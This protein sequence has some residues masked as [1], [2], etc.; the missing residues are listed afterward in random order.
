MAP[1]ISSTDRQP[2]VLSDAELSER[3]AFQAVKEH[4]AKFYQITDISRNGAALDTVA[5]ASKIKEELRARN[6]Q[7]K[8]I[9][10]LVL[11]V[12]Q[13]NIVNHRSINQ[14]MG[15]KDSLGCYRYSQRTTEQTKAIWNVIDEGPRKLHEAD[16]AAANRRRLCTTGSLTRTRTAKRYVSLTLPPGLP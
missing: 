6:L 8:L 13:G 10:E 2:V 16:K 11:D 1:M 5:V 12:G 4:F 15:K 7:Q 9:G 14:P 3:E